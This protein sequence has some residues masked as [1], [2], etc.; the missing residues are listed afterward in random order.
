MFYG[1]VTQKLIKLYKKYILLPKLNY[2]I[3]L[4]TFDLKEKKTGG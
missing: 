1:M 2:V 4:N 3:M